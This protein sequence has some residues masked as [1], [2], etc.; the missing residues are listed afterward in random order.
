MFEKWRRGLE[1]K[2]GARLHLGEPWLHAAYC[3]LVFIEGHGLYAI[4]AGVLGIVVVLLAIMG[5]E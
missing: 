3:V 4:A 5:D 1:H 2:I